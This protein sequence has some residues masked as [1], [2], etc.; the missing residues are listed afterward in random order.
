MVR[1]HDAQYTFHSGCEACTRSL[2]IQKALLGSV[3]LVGW[4]KVSCAT[5]CV[6]R[7][8]EGDA[9]QRPAS[10]LRSGRL[11]AAR[12]DRNSTINLH[13]TMA[14]HEHDPPP[15]EAPALTLAALPD[16]LLLRILATLSQED[17][18]VKYAP[19]A[20][21][22]SLALEECWHSLP[23]LWPAPMP[24]FAACAWWPP[25][26][27]LPPYAT[28]AWPTQPCPAIPHRFRHASLVCK[29]FRAL[30]L[31]PALM[32][33]ISLRAMTAPL[34]RFR[35]LLR[36]LAAHAEHVRCLELRRCADLPSQA[37]LPR[38]PGDR[39]RSLPALSSQ[40]N[41]ARLCRT[42]STPQSQACLTSPHLNAAA[43]RTLTRRPWRR[44]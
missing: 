32:H 42:P 16:E 29:R 4:Q 30:C 36:F 25:S 41:L 8:M 28:P 10:A 19:M 26:P 14:S 38:R 18:Q 17:R 27:I 3:L 21:E 39:Q 15:A 40:H 34:P 2:T 31:A 37:R 35:A 11:H 9:S 13:R 20:P 22:H 33:R 24:S 6:R 12:H 5:E 43:I 1:R 23:L 44:R 7:H